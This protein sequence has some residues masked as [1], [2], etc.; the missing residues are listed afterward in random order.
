[1]PMPMMMH[2]APQPC[3]PPCAP[4]RSCPARTLLLVEDSHVAAEAVR[5]MFRHAGGRLRRADC[6]R[7]ARRHLAL[8]TPDALLVDIGLPDGSGL[9][10]IRLGERQR[11]RV[12]LILAMSGEPDMRD[13]ALMAGADHFVTKPFASITAFCQLLA[14]VFGDPRGTGPRAPAPAPDEVAL[15]T[16][17]QLACDML[18]GCT[19]GARQGYALQFTAALAR[20]LGDAAL[21]RA[22]HQAR[23]DGNVTALALVLRQRLRNTALI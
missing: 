8:Y 2:A 23:K 4:V 19:S 13:A 9:E 14:P 1:M 16:D 5:A 11:P 17:L 18:L 3:P 15:R 12:P 10:L 20:S 7:D 22:V 21:T 6:L